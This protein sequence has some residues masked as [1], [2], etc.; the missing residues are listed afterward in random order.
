MS[1]DSIS[2]ALSS[3]PAHLHQ[4]VEPIK[5]GFTSHITQQHNEESSPLLSVEVLC[6]FTTYT[7]TR[8][9]TETHQE[10][11]SHLWLHQVQPQVQQR[12]NIHIYAASQPEST[13]DA[14][15]R[16]ISTYY[17]AKVSANL[18]SIPDSCPSLIRSQAQGASRIYAIFGGQGNNK[19]YFN[20]LR[21]IYQTYQPFLSDLISDLDSLLQTLSQ[22]PRISHLYPEGLQVKKWLEDSET[23]P[24]ADYLITAPLSFPLIGL[25]QL[26][27]L[28]AISMSLDGTPADFP[29]IFQGLAGHSQGVIVAAAVAATETWEDYAAA[30]RK[31]VTILFWIGARSQQVWRQHAL[32]ED[33]AARLEDEG[34]GK[35]SPMLSISSMEQSQL[36]SHLARLNRTLPAANRAYISLVNSSSNFVVSGPERTLAALI[37]SLKA[38]SAKD[39]QS[40]ARVPYSQRKP[41]PTIRFLP[42]TI[43]CHCPLLDEAVPLIDEDLRNLSIR[44]S[45]LRVPVNNCHKGSALKPLMGRVSGTTRSSSN[46]VPLLV[47]MITSEPVFWAETDF[48]AATHILDFGPGGTSGVGALTHRNVAGAGVRVIIVGKLEKSNTA[49]SDLGS[50]YD[51][52]SHDDDDDN[53]DPQQ[54]R[55]SRAAD[56]ATANSG[57]LVQTAS[58]PV[59]ATKL[60]RLLGLPPSSSP[61]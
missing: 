21:N 48:T 1:S 28:K 22:D 47:R 36:D 42:I 50:L 25:L 31:A 54:Q 20:E 38:A 55:S 43:P 18:P 13:Q 46:L 45:E 49:D 35:A 2:R 34:H 9:D 37:S 59:I 11:A 57:S 32:A 41:S 6:L 17:T 10:L 53:A 8:L 5:E 61:A 60:S 58:G 7:S 40:Q 39:A 51:V 24:S 14:Q 52:F 27:T 44:A 29:G 56:W 26:A 3:I 23:T 19:H 12:H 30:T 4:Q 16:L 15:R 33:I